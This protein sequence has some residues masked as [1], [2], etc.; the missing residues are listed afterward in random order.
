MINEIH[1]YHML[2]EQI[3]AKMR[4][5]WEYFYNEVQGDQDDKKLYQFLYRYVNINKAVSALKSELQELF[6]DREKYPSFFK[7]ILNRADMDDTFQYIVRLGVQRKFLKN[8]VEYYGEVKDFKFTDYEDVITYLFFYC[9][10]LT[11]DDLRQVAIADAYID[12]ACF[13]LSYAGEPGELGRAY[14][15]GLAIRENSKY[16]DESVLDTLLHYNI[17]SQELANGVRYKTRYM[18]QMISN[19]SLQ[20]RERSVYKFYYIDRYQLHLHLGHFFRK[21]FDG[22]YPDSVYQYSTRNEVLVNKE[23][24]EK[25]IQFIIERKTSDKRDAIVYWIVERG[26]RSRL[27]LFLRRDTIM[28]QI[29]DGQSEALPFMPE[30]ERLPY[31]EVERVCNK[32]LAVSVGKEYLE[33]LYLYV[34]NLYNKGRQYKLAFSH[35]Y[36]YDFVQEEDKKC[37]RVGQGHRKTPAG[38]FHNQG[39]GKGRIQNI[40]AL[41]GRN[42]SGKTSVARLLTES[43]IFGIRDHSEQNQYCVIF[44]IGNNLY[45][46]SNMDDIEVEVSDTQIQLSRLGEGENFEQFQGIMNTAVVSYNNFLNPV[47]VGILKQTVSRPVESA[48]RYNLTTL[49]LLARDL[50]GNIQTDILRIANLCQDLEEQ[51]KDLGIVDLKEVYLYADKRACGMIDSSYREAC[52]KTGTGEWFNREL[53]FYFNYNLNERGKKN[54]QSAKL[55]M[56]LYCKWY[57]ADIIESRKLYRSTDLSEKDKGEIKAHLVKQISAYQELDCRY[58]GDTTEENTGSVCYQWRMNLANI[59]RCCA[60]F[61]E[62]L[63][64]KGILFLEL[65][66]MSTGESAR[67]LLFARLHAVFRV[68]EA[69]TAFLPSSSEQRNF[70][71]VLDEIEAFFHPTWQRDIVYDLI[72]FLEWESET[73]DAY[74]NIQI[75]LS[76]NAP[77]FLSDLPKDSLICLDEESMGREQTYSSFG[78]NIHTILKNSFLLKDGLMGKFAQ[79]KIEAA[80]AVLQDNE[81]DQESLEE[82]EYIVDELEEPIIKHALAELL[83]R[84]KDRNMGFKER[85][86]AKYQRQVEELQEK[87]NRLQSDMD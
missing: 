66:Q 43:E 4:E 71:L 10:G 23:D 19:S 47:N 60:L 77:F 70:I 13:A 59:A 17:D 49:E 29:D 51:S 46:V 33:L 35:E 86:L 87:I 14:K 64:G 68:R 6:S 54:R 5:D 26:K 15:G 28:F 53:F 1:Y 67:L 56:E 76:S 21:Y 12:T 79:Q 61:G 40:N 81:T 38:F 58:C 22:K 80:F 44:K 37:I 83:E 75:I 82:V 8:V 7:R 27:R 42:G 39:K 78:Q 85:E 25:K 72:D 50:K 3:H 84:T 24:R 48:M 62:M 45:W 36:Q 57:I 52:R 41:I 18:L 11:M 34:D 55:L 31:Q 9:Q 30:E 69:Y 73:F 32:L 16:L 74:D 20:S 63:C 65:P 2:T